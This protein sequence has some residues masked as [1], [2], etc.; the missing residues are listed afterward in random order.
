MAAHVFISHAKDDQASAHWWCRSL[1][2]DGLDCWIAQRDI[3]PGA[4][5]AE[6]I[7][8][9]LEAARAVLLLLS[10]SAMASPQVRREV[11]RATHKQVPLIALRLD[12][13]PLT[14]T[15]EYFL[16]AQHWIA[17]PG[18]E[19]RKHRAGVVNALRALASGAR[20]LPAEV[21]GGAPALAPVHWPSAVL[22]AAAERLAQHVGPIAAALVERAARR[23]HNEE[24]LI[25]LLG[26]EIDDAQAR[27]RFVAASRKA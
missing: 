2:E 3:P 23:A 14:K 13:A 10:A 4:D 11:E 7:I 16:S 9:G 20:A 24:E 8:E 15:F 21:Q 5:W 27:E 25:G 18:G 12:D 22:D 6:R 17:A 19:A 1:E 26:E